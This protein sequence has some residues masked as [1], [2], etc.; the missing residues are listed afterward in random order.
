MGFKVLNTDSLEGYLRYANCWWIPTGFQSAIELLSRE[1]TSA[2]KMLLPEVYLLWWHWKQLWSRS[3]WSEIQPGEKQV[4]HSRESFRQFPSNARRYS[5]RR[6]PQFFRLTRV[7]S[8]ENRSCPVWLFPRIPRPSQVAVAGKITSP[9]WRR[10][11]W[12]AD[13]QEKH[14][15]SWAPLAEIHNIIK[16]G[17]GNQRG[18]MVGRQ[19][20]SAAGR[21]CAWVG[22][23]ELPISR[24]STNLISIQ[25]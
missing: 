2:T 21:M 16:S 8:P 20:L 4:P 11:A 15:K 25:G 14:S 5:S 10:W 1:K 17:A 13:F 19:K 22:N 3:R 12:K 9:A 18:T 24:N 7:Y 23:A 6:A